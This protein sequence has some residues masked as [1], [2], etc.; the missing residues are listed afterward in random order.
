MKQ[1]LLSNGVVLALLLNI[2][3]NTS[4]FGQ[5]TNKS[6][7]DTI[8]NISNNKNKP[9]MMV[10]STYLL[11]NG[12]CKQAMEFY[13]SCFGG[14]LTQTSVGQSPM[15]N[16]FPDSMHDK[17]VNARLIGENFDI[18]ASDWLRPA[19]T[20]VRGNMVCLYLSGG[21]PRQLKAIFD[22]LS[23]EADVTDP[24]KLEVFGTYGALN[25]KFGVR[26]MFHTDQR[27]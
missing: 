16:F 8:E 2:G 6:R 21:N 25:D 19:Q 22:T 20:P 10:L 7:V 9:Q 13:K 26:W 4:A 24:L 12:D 14:E 18:T 23:Q 11:F 3:F 1:N 5:K 27:D 17:T 15:K